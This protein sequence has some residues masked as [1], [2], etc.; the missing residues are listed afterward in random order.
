MKLNTTNLE[1]LAIINGALE[2]DVVSVELKPEA[3]ALII[4][5]AISKSKPYQ[6][7]ITATYKFLPHLDSLPSPKELPS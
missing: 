4:L 2:K 7:D 6:Y 3:Q 5:T 1:V